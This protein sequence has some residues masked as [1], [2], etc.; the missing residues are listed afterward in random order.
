MLELNERMEYDLSLRSVPDLG[1]VMEGMWRN[2]EY[3]AQQ[4]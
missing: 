1:K 3:F 2:Y 4:V